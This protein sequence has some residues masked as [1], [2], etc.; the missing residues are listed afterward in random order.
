MSTSLTSDQTWH[1]TT[2]TDIQE[3]IKGE[4]WRI[5]MSHRNGRKE[6]VYALEETCEV[7]G[8][9]DPDTMDTTDIPNRIR[10]DW[11]T[12]I[13]NRVSDKR[14]WDYLSWPNAEEYEG[15][16]SK[17][18]LKRIGTDKDGTYLKK[19]AKRYILASLVSN[20]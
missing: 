13:Q 17:L 5:D 12:H 11:E 16:I 19:L 2:I 4:I 1:Q 3:I 20:S 14:I 18:W 6:S 10:A 9:A 7:I 15:G 8:G